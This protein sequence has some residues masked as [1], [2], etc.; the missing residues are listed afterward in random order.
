[1]VTEVAQVE[2]GTQTPSVFQTYPWLLPLIIVVIA[3]LIIK[4][5]QQPGVSQVSNAETIEWVDDF[6]KKQTIRIT[7]NVRAT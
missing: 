7:R 3:Y 2:P 4:A 6:G 1:M 5:R